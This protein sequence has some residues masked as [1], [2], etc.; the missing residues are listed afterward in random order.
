MIHLLSLPGQPLNS[1][2][3]TPE[4]ESW[5]SPDVKQ[6]LIQA[7][8]WRLAGDGNSAKFSGEVMTR[9]KGFRTSGPGFLYHFGG[10]QGIFETGTRFTRLA[11]EPAVRVKDGEGK[12]FSG[13]EFTIVDNAVYDYK[14]DVIRLKADQGVEP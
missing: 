14:K 10:K 12:D 11:N 13:N 8:T 1:V 6:I 2:G 7:N 3:L 5:S 4:S 9:L